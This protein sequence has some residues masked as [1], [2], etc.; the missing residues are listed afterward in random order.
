M[1]SVAKKAIVVTCICYVHWWRNVQWNSGL[2][3]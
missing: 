3:R 2:I 1:K